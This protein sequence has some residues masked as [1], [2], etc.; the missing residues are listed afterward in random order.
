MQRVT[1]N[2]HISLQVDRYKQLLLKQRDIMIALTA[3]LNERDEQIM[4]LQVGGGWPRAEA[5]TLA[6]QGL[7]D[8]N[9][10]ATTYEMAGGVHLSNPQLRLWPRACR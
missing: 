4:T 3:R 9:R 8:V 1:T 2:Q 6:D 7:V 5:C 10:R